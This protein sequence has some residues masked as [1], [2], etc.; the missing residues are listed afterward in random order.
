[1]ERERIVMTT[2]FLVYSQVRLLVYV[3]INFVL[4]TGEIGWIEGFGFGGMWIVF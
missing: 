1:M 3:F 4:L 2:V